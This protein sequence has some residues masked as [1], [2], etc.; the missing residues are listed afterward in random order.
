MDKLLFGAIGLVFGALGM[1]FFATPTSSSS[2]AASGS[3]YLVVTG[4]VLD[5]DAFM[6]G[7][8]SQLDPLY[9]RHGGSYV[10]L[11]GNPE[12]LE[13][14]PAP[15][16]VISKWPSRT[17]AHA[18]WNDPDYAPLKAARIESGWAELD[19]ALVDG[20]PP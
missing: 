2:N 6:A 8:A 12:P 19:V 9:E 15:S 16:L 5:H 17:A 1:K 4:K 7:Y 14:Q 11:G 10:I 18:F 13:G 3:A 20:T